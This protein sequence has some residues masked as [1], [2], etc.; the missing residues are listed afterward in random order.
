MLK[1]SEASLFK[2]K[3]GKRTNVEEG[4]KKRFVT[5]DGL[6][7]KIVRPNSKLFLSKG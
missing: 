3:M 7:D 2:I 4:H 1:V 6:S 5:L